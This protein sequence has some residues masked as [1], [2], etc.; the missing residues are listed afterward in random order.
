[1]N[2]IV[3]E[4]YTC[5]EMNY[6][7]ALKTF[8]LPTLSIRRDVLCKAKVFFMQVSKP[9][10]KLDYLLEKRNEHPC[11]LRHNQ[12]YK[13]EISLSERYENSC[14]MHSLVHYS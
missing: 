7:E 4:R 6:H 9:E 2:V 12:M 10:H 3:L 5:T 13:I 14:I 1:M 11:G 8:K